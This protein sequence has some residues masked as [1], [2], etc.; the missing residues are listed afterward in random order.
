MQTT[1]PITLEDLWSALGEEQHRAAE[2]LWT[3][4]DPRVEEE[5]TESSRS[6]PAP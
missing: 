1:T 6:S 2:A 4:A 3:S 5:Q